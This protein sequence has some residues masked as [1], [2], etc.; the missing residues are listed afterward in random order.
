MFTLLIQWDVGTCNN[1]KNV[2]L[3]LNHKLL[4]LLLIFE[5]VSEEIN[6]NN[7]YSC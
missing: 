4:I 6:G 7:F 5:S 1:G 3:E 2:F